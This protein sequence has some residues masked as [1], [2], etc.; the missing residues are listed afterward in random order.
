MC[1]H[2]SYPFVKITL[3]VLLL[4]VTSTAFACYNEYTQQNLAGKENTYL[5]FGLP[6]FF[7]SFDLAFS[8]KFIAAYNLS[9]LPVTDFKTR[10]DISVHLCRLGRY[11]EALVILRDLYKRYPEEYN[12]MSNLGTTYELVGK[13]DSALLILRKANQI[14]PVGHS[15]TEWVHLKVLEAKLEIRKD[16]VWLLHHQVLDMGI[17][18]ASKLKSQEFTKNNFTIDAVIYQLTERIPFTPTPDLLLANVL[19][20]LADATALEHSITEAY[21]LY[22]IALQYDPQDAF[23]I[24]GK[25]KHLEGLFKKYKVEK[26]PDYQ[27]LQYH[28]PPVESIEGD[29]DDTHAAYHDQAASIGALEAATKGDG[30]PWYYWLGGATL[31]CAAGI[32]LATRA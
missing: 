3:S 21:V 16:P 4:T 29:G 10:S 22:H 1:K 11:T 9:T 14:N 32:F 28:F 26:V 2:V 15:G 27:T 8:E 24:Q 6:Q 23:G 19:N 7:R 13:P 25:M 12:V 31:L 5:H 18:K 30:A 17:A 20:E